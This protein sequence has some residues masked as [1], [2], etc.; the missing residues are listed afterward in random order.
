MTR[1]WPCGAITIS[2]RDG[3]LCKSVIVDAPVQRHGGEV[4]CN[5][6]RGRTQ[7]GIADGRGRFKRR[8]RSS[9]E[10]RV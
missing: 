6:H 8:E 5:R 7:R 2:D 3:R 10:S 1:S 9:P 4:F